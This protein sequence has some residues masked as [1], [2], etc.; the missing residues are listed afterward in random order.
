M[1]GWLELVSASVLASNWLDAFLQMD[2][3]F[4]MADNVKASRGK[5]GFY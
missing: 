5:H 1:H 2:L 3:K 4:S